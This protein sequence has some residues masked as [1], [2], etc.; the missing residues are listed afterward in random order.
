VNRRN[1]RRRREGAV[2][3]VSVVPTFGAVSKN[4]TAVSPQQQPCSPIV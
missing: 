1:A 3:G 2:P 4:Y